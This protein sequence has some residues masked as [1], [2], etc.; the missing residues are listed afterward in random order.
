[1]ASVVLGVAGFV[2]L[3]SFAVFGITGLN[4]KS[5][6]RGVCSPHCTDAQVSKLKTD[7]VV[8]DVSLG[9][10]LIA[11]GVA[12]FLWLTDTSSKPASYGRFARTIWK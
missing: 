11:L 9:V 3:G 1:M 12:T 6:L 10:G 2:A 4:E 8:G 5:R 7:Y